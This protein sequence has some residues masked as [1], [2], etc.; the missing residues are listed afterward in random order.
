MQLS[1][2]NQ[3]IE[4]LSANDANRKIREGWVLLTVVATTHPSGE[5]HPCYVLG[6]I[7]EN[8]ERKDQASEL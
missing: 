1:D 3:V 2:A 5:I 4:A 8:Q 7:A 6:K